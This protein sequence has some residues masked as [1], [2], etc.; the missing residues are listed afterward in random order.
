[1]WRT[2]YLE[3]TGHLNWTHAAR[4]SGLIGLRGRFCAAI[5]CILPTTDRCARPG[6]VAETGPNGENCHTL[7]IRMSYAC[8]T[9]CDR[10][11]PRQINAMTR[12]AP[13][14]ANLPRAP[15]QAFV[16]RRAAA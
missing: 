3:L 6:V 14:C 5:R 10:Q 2:G 15:R 13:V 9:L 7:V 1:M 8:H 12:A 4:R 11:K 16:N